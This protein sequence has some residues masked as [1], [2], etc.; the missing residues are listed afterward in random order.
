MKAAL[1]EADEGGTVWPGNTQKDSR[2]SVI[3]MLCIVI[4]TEGDAWRMLELYMAIL[5]KV[6]ACA[7]VAE[8]SM[9]AFRCLHCECNPRKAADSFRFSH[10]GSDQV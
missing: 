5:R 8:L 3:Q 1:F 4:L 9:H 2:A 10:R 7:P 6:T